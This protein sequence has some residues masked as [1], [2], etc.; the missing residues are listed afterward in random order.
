MFYMIEMKLI[1]WLGNPW[2]EY[3]MTRHNAGFLMID[4]LA[5]H[6]DATERKVDKWFNAHVTVVESWVRKIVF[7][8]PQTFMN[9][10]WSS[11]ASIAHFYK[12]A[13]Q[14]I[15]VIHD[16]IDFEPGR[17]EFKMGGSAAGHNGLKDIIAKLG[18][19]DFA[20]IRVGVGRPADKADVADYVLSNFKKSE[21][22]GIQNQ[23]DIINGIVLDF[24]KN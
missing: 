7:V 23:V 8:K 6:W 3:E 12:I 4:E 15:L 11:V 18:T 19:N 22:M 24:I 14:N 2:K 9:R 20:R 5:K 13:P 1:V 10:S 17:V 16:E 21:W